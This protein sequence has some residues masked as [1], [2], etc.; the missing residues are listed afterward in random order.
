M[1]RYFRRARRFIFHNIL[2][3]DD[4][5][6]AIALGAGIAM[7]IAFLPL[8][9]FQTAIAVGLAALFRANKA[10]CIPIVWITNPLT[11]GPIYLGC[12][13]LGQ[14]VLAS[15]TQ[16]HG[17]EVL[18]RIQH[19]VESFRFFDRQSWIDVFQLLAGLSME[20]WV[21]CAIVGL[22]FGVVSYV[23]AHRGVVFYRERRRL[24]VLR[25]NLFRAQAK[26]DRLAR[27]DSAV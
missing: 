18:D 9:G 15:P 5:P 1:A 7:V 26:K 12:V 20:L 23:A 24:R 4:T 16:E 8:V 2:H 14:V 6:H 19:L 10:V 21:G 3:A 17:A 22:A 25:R 11:M 27:E 13:A